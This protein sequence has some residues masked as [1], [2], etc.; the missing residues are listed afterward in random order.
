MTLYIGI[1]CLVVAIAV[2]IYSLVSAP[3]EPPPTLGLRGLKR[4]RALAASTGFALFEPIIRKIGGWI[5]HLPLRSWRR[6]S[7]QLLSSAGDFLGLTPN[8]YLALVVLGAAGGL[9][10]GGVVV[11]GLNSTPLLALLL[12]GFGAWMPWS[13]V[14]GEAQRR[15]R[16][17]EREL[18][19]TIELIALCMS[20]GL[21]FTGAIKQ[22]TA[23]HGLEDTPLR[24]E[25]QRILRELELGHSRRRALESLAL[26]VPSESVR[27]FV[28]AVVQSEERGNPLRDVL[29]VQATV[30]R[31]RRSILA[32]EAAAHASVA[33]IGPLVM[34]LSATLLLLAGPLFIKAVFSAGGL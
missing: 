20:A 30:L 8:E 2:V 25:L 12:A 14:L 7:A 3:A 24:E 17:I 28:A 19:A 32:E 4:Q 9:L 13:I 27:D 11:I 18:P 5:A 15:R 10:I 16:S 34:L 31:T 29:R 22:A 33:M 26:R 6:R 21:D 1:T 23:D